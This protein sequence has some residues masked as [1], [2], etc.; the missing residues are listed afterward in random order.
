MCLLRKLDR[1]LV[2]GG[3][4]VLNALFPELNPKKGPGKKLLELKKEIFLKNYAPKLKPTNGTRE[5]IKAL[6]DKGLQLI[7]ASSA[8]KDDLSLLLKAARVDDLIDKSTTSSD[9]KR[10]KPAPDIIIAALK[11]IQLQPHEVILIG[12]TPYDI[13]SAEKCGVKTITLR[14]GGFPEKSLKGAYA[15]FEDPKDLLANLK[16]LLKKL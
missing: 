4:Q 7:A 9:V 1:L 15:I 6:K 2:L 12:D 8:G 13:E 3:E 11:K 16:T 5:L 10:A 14:C